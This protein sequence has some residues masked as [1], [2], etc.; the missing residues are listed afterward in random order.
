[1]RKSKNAIPPKPKIRSNPVRFKAS[2]WCRLNKNEPFTIPLLTQ[3]LGYN[4]DS[5]HDT[6]MV[7]TDVVLYWRNKAIEYYDVLK[8]YGLLNNMDHYQAWD[9]LL[10]NYNNNDAYVFLYDDNRGSYIQPD[11]DELE[12]MDRK[13]LKKQ[14]GGILSVMD[15]M[16]K[17]EALFLTNGIQLPVDRLQE[18]GQRFDG[19]LSNNKK[20]E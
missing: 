11:M 18:A 7:Y 5:R 1:M 9:V 20:E 17:I 3:Y 4:P 16:K 12:Q 15:E 19:L 2:K 8:K 13:R 10:E 6:N 14:W